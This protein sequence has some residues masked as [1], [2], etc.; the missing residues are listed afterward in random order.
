MSRSINVREPH[1]RVIA[2]GHDVDEAL[3]DGEP[4]L[5]AR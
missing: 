5:D 4:R 2:F 1:A 3:L